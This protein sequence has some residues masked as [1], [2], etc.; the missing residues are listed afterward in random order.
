[1]C[2]RVT[3]GKGAFAAEKLSEPISPEQV[4]WPED[5]FTY[6]G[7][8]FD[9]WPAGLV[10]KTLALDPSKGRDSKAGD[11]S[12]LI[13]LGVDRERVLYVEADLQRRPT[14]HMV[15]DAVEVVRQFQPDG[16]AVEVNQFQELLCVEFQRAGAEQGIHLPLYSIN[17]SVNKQVRIRRL[18]PYLAQ[19]RLRFKSRSPSTALLVQQLRD[20]PQAEHDDGP[21][22]LEMASRLATELLQGL[23]YVG[24]ESIPPVR[25]ERH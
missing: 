24:A 19:R 2:L 17:N 1:M 4:E 22:S 18:G 16:F 11:Y 23:H 6:P 15:A 14:S 3:I 21:D 8:W 25:F 20:F 12:A 7:F 13:R 9:D 10:L 5:Y